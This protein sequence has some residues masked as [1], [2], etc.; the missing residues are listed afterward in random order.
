MFRINTGSS[1]YNVQSSASYE[2]S[3]GV[4][5]YGLHDNLNVRAN[6]TKVTDYVGTKAANQIP[7]LLS[8]ATFQGDVISVANSMAVL[9]A[10]GQ[11][12]GNVIVADL[13]KAHLAGVQ[14]VLA[15]AQSSG[16]QEAWL[17]EVKR[18]HKSGYADHLELLIQRN[19]EHLSFDSLK[20]RLHRGGVSIV[21]ADM[22]SDSATEL[23]GLAPHGVSGMYVSNIEMYLGGFL[24]K[25]NTSINERQQALNAFKNNIV[26]L[27]GAEAF[28]IRGESVGMQVHNKNAAINDWI[29]QVR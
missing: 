1:S 14:S 18:Q 9:A 5:S 28:L 27:M 25:A 22:A 2:G 11:G 21:Q 17:R 19:Q 12:H 26:S 29:P 24:D 6:T 23:A 7:C 13:D 4:K 15:I 3:E 8:N 10:M 16:S 20:Q